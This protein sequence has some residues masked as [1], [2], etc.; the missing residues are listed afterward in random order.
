MC[1]ICVIATGAGVGIAHRLGIDDSIVGLW[2]GGLLAGF[3]LWLLAWARRYSWYTYERELWFILVYYAINLVPVW[4]FIARHACP[5]S[6]CKF[7]A[8]FILGS[9]VFYA[10]ACAINCSKKR[11]H[12]RVFFP[13]QK[14]LIPVIVLTFLSVVLYIVTA[15]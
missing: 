14:V 1:P 10:L 12:G 8:G 5:I 15:R 7:L 3:L 4:F 6:I 9:F 11:R 13:F 2:C